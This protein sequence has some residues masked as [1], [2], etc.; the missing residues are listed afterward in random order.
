MGSVGGAAEAQIPERSGSKDPKPQHAAVDSGTQGL[1]PGQVRRTPTPD[2]H[3]G[4]GLSD[5][6]HDLVKVLKI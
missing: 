4:P 1:L 2:P 6:C 5:G 3:S